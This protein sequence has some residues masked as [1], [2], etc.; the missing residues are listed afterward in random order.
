VS[1][2]PGDPANITINAA[3]SRW[4]RDIAERLARGG[5]YEGASA[6]QLE[7]RIWIGIALS[8]DPA[9]AC[10]SIGFARGKPTFAAALQAA[11]LA[12]STRYGYEIEEISDQRAVIRFLRDGKPAG[13]SCFTM[14]EARRAGLT[15]KSVWQAY[16]SDLLFARAMTRGIRRFAPDLLAGSVSYTAEEVGED[17]HEPIPPAITMPAVINISDEQLGHLKQ[18]KDE[19]EIPVD[20]WRTMLAKRNVTSARQLTASQADELI[21]K[22]RHRT[23]T[24]QLEDAMTE[25]DAAVRARRSGDLTV[26]VPVARKED[27]GAAGPAHKSD[28][29]E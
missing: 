16:P 1:T 4:I 7:A 17:T 19:L 26:D 22:L 27:K 8:I 14:E 6:A 10:G 3:T 24:K 2:T 20:A 23:A 25:Q 28:G 21:S 13:I 29:G 15:S 9:T 18:L 12:H 11:L 5:P